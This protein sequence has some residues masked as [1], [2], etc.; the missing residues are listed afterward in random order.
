MA[1]EWLC[2]CV[3]TPS[4]PRIRQLLR[5]ISLLGRWLASG[6]DRGIAHF[7]MA[8]RN[9]IKGVGG[10]I[11]NEQYAWVNSKCK[12]RSYVTLHSLAWISSEISTKLL[13]MPTHLDRSSLWTLSHATSLS[14][15]RCRL[16]TR[17]TLRQLPSSEFLCLTPDGLSLPT[18]CHVK[19]AG[20][21][22]CLVSH[23]NR[24]RDR[25]LGGLPT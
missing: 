22:L 21:G 15:V 4:A 19:I 3:D 25:L 10:K 14:D 11:T 12:K 1:Q 20:S 5:A 16:A 18:S 24:Q 2:P 8:T 7:F 17:V 6:S 13:G 9:A 23:Q